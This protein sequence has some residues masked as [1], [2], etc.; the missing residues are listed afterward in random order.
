MTTFKADLHCHT[1]FSD[2]TDSPEELIVL[3][4]KNGLSALSI[5]DHDTIS[6]YAE[7]IPAAKKNGIILGAGAEFSSSYDG[8]N[9]HI[10]AYDFDLESPLIHA[11]CQKHKERRKLRNY[12]ILEK[13][14]KRQMPIPEEELEK[15]GT[16]TLGRPHIAELLVKHRFV[17]SVQ[18]A[19][20]L[21]IGDGKICY[22]AGEPF[23]VD[24]TLDLIHS[25]RGKA[26]LAHPHF[27]GEG[28]KVFKLLEKPFDGIECLYAN[29]LPQQEK[30]WIKAAERRGLLISGGSDYHGTLKPMLTLGCSFVNE[31]TFYKIFQHAIH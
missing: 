4:K 3:A 31:E 8:L 20:D 10:L 12:R 28:E 22:D 13:L 6:A 18:Q 9:V 27:L 19:F 15:M 17:T 11:F 16:E 2:G 24:E 7:A 23:T 30:R 1:Y 26:F 29:C 14:K 25:A 21:Y 5:T